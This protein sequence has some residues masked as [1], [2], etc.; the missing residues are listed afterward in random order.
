[1]HEI[2]RSLPWPFEKAEFPPNLGAVVQWTVADGDLPAL[3]VGHT[4]ANSWLVGDGV[5]DPNPAG[6][7][8]AMCIWAAIEHNSSMREL[9][10]LPVGWAAERDAPGAPWHRIPFQLSD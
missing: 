8:A 1:M 5:N 10:D 9:A 2:L 7:C 6:A 3:F 4:E